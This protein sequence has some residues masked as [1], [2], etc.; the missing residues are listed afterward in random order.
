MRISGLGSSWP[1]NMPDQPG[2]VTN[3]CTWV[4]NIYARQS[5]IDFLL[6]AAPNDPT[7]IG[8]TQ[9]AAAG[10]GAAAGGMVGDVVGG[11][12]SGFGDSLGNQLGVPGWAILLGVAV[13]G[14]YLIKAL[15]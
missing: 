12:S 13:G 1:T 3:P 9:G 5:C 4:D 2:C 14:I 11:V 7:T 6:C 10:A 15:K 8:L